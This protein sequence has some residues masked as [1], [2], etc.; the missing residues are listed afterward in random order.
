MSH[1]QGPSPSL[2]GWNAEF[3]LSMLEQFRTDPNSVDASWKYFF[4]GFELAQ[5]LG[6]V[7]APKS[8]STA[9]STSGNAGS[10]NLQSKIDSLI[11][12][13]R[14]VGHMQAKI[15]PLGHRAT[16]TPLLDLAN[17][18]LSEENMDQVF[19]AG[20]FHYGPENKT[21]R[22]LISYLNATYC[23]SIGVE[24]MDIQNTPERRWL[25][26]KMEPSLNQ[27][28]LPTETRIRAAQLLYKS[29]AFEK[30]IQSS[31]V[32]QKRFSLEGAETLIPVLDYLINNSAEH[33]VEQV[34]MG[35]A[36]RGRL[37]VLANTLKKSYAE[38]FTEFEDN[39]VP[40]TIM[41]DGDV[42]YHKGYSCDH[43][44][45]KGKTVHLSLTANPSH[46]E[47]VDPVVLGRVRAKQRNIGDTDRKRVLG[48]LM[49]GDAAFA[50]QGIVS[51][52]LN[53][54]QLEGYKT[55]GTIHVIINNQIGF[56]TIPK[57]ARSGEYC[58]DV[59]KMIQ[60]PIFHV[61]G[62]DPDACLRVAKLASEFRAKFQKDV[63]IDIYCYRRHGH[64]EGD[65]PSFTQPTLYEEIKVHPAPF[66]IYNKKLVEAG[67]ITEAQINS[68]ADVLDADLKKAQKAAHAKPQVVNNEPFHKEWEGLTSAYSFA[69]VKTTVPKKTL[70]EIAASWTKFPEGFTPHRKVTGIMEKRQQTVKAG[71][72]IDWAG[73]EALA[74]GSLLLDKVP[75]RISG[76]DSR[77]G[78]FSHRHA[79]VR[80]A[81]DASPYIPMNFIRPDQ[82][83]FC[84]YDSCLSE[85]GVLGF[86][87]GYSLDNPH[88][89][90]C[91]EAQFGDFANGAQTIIDQFIC[92][93]ES[94]WTRASGLVMLLPHG[95]EGQGPEHSS[96]WLERFLQ[97]SA[98][99]NIQVCNMT[100]P[101]QLFHVLRRQ[102]LRNFR[103]PLVIMSPKSGLR[104]P[105]V[106]SSLKDFTDGSFHEIL[107]DPR[108][109]DATKVK[110][111]VFCS[112]KVYYDL[113]E[114][115]E[116]ADHSDVALIRLEQIY[117]FASE[118][119]EAILKRY[120][121]AN[122]YVWCQEETQNKGAWSF[123]EPIMREQFGVNMY[124]AGRERAASPAV[125]SLRLHKLE[126][127]AL[128]DE[129]FGKFSTPK[130]KSIK[131]S[132]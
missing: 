11:Y 131:A 59:A 117:P 62:D 122:E 24:Y 77:R 126:Q 15:D 17:F 91:W 26:E 46:L 12:H 49:H 80:D 41:G 74:I 52:V 57:D 18:K 108:T 6:I 88:M 45:P 112:G 19:Y 40:N 31:Y 5:Q 125:G 33:D 106:V 28:E 115:T 32:G 81:E 9:T 60:A 98:E 71:E 66:E 87:Y 67:I 95:Y 83:R 101:A 129:A 94:K 7:D 56:T 70:L 27:E 4:Q 36:H 97:L 69:P 55:G 29:T 37:N 114:R 58:T 10:I 34:V 21:L 100:D 132:A 76:Q 130:M 123:V 119:M 30:F 22:E 82:S 109:K 120:T 104:N 50:G 73:A 64:N 25:Q 47:A 107:D 118:K 1:D 51:E 39:H 102:Q 127:Q 85:S 84:V 121:K 103:K 20:H 23:G 35:M 111:L 116:L 54:S 92:T 8:S 63:V 42:K 110:R 78:T 75:V 128:L 99:D 3:V 14:D 93:S 86:D 79:V 68:M 2:N 48:I 65:E 44:T 61:N 53:L 72:G 124:Y 43:I 38:I 16:K 113:L 90:I 96:G 89:M 13:Y 105:R